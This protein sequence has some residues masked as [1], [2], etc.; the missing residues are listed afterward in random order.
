VPEPMSARDALGVAGITA[1][2]VIVAG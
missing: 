1:G 2:L